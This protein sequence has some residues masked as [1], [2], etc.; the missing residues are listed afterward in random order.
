VKLSTFPIFGAKHVKGLT[1][2]RV[3]H[4]HTVD[5]AGAELRVEQGVPVEGSL[6]NPAVGPQHGKSAV[7]A[8]E[9]DLAIEV[10]EVKTGKVLGYSYITGAAIQCMGYEIAPHR[11]EPARV[12]RLTDLER[13]V[14][15]AQA[16]E[17]DQDFGAHIDKMINLAQR[18][19]H[20]DDDVAVL[21]LVIGDDFERVAKFLLEA[22][23]RF[24]PGKTEAEAP[25]WAKVP[26]DR[27]CHL[28]GRVWRKKLKPSPFRKK[29]QHAQMH[30]Q[31]ARHA[32][33]HCATGFQHDLLQGMV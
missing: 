5:T 24:E 10:G 6:P 31:P 27:R 16:C 11:F 8:V 20:G 29:P 3:L 22:W 23:S 7:R 30:L 28:F 21:E 13:Q 17:S 19:R 1:L 15:D 33:D 18:A 25:A 4:P 14:L 9:G 2:L 26:A 12:V 32:S